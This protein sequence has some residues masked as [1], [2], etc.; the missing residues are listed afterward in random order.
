[1]AD[2]HKCYRGYRERT[3]NTHLRRDLPRV[4]DRT[5]SVEVVFIGDSHF[6][7]LL[8]FGNLKNH[9]PKNACIAAVGGDKIEHV[10]YRLESALGILHTLSKRKET[11]KVVFMAGGNNGLHTG[12]RNVRANI[13]EMVNNVRYIIAL[14]QQYLPGAGIYIWAIPTDPALCPDIDTYN[15]KLESMCRDARD[16]SVKFSSSVHNATLAS[17]H[18]CLDIW[19]DQVH[20]NEKGYMQCVLPH[21]KEI[22]EADKVGVCPSAH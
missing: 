13:D 10:M 6:E 11:R 21:I 4:K 17:D 18:C 7:R 22:C 19:D 2:E 1:M 20:M 5:K 12:V 16:E 15:R 14:I 8:T 3:H 9:L